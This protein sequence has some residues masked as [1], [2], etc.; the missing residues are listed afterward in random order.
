V[1]A[2]R[3][4]AALVGTAVEAGIEAVEAAEAAI[5]TLE[6]NVSSAIGS[7]TTLGIA[8]KAIAVINVTALG[9]S[10]VTARTA[11]MSLRAI[12]ARSRDI[13]PGIAPNSNMEAAGEVGATEIPVLAT[14][15]GNT[16]T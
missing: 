4:A 1:S 14:I 2:P 9:T 5:I 11:L 12:I 8:R 13:L 15:V 10:P 3:K 16:G 6:T 7:D